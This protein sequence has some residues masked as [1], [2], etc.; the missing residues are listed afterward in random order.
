MSPIPES[1]KHN[2]LEDVWKAANGLSPEEQLELV[3]KLIH[4]LRR[5]DSIE[6][7]YVDWVDLCGLGKG[8]WERDDAQDY[9]NRLRE[10]RT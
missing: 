6:E 3:E 4:T 9:V 7:R 2:S 10:D 8:L 5:K 1:R